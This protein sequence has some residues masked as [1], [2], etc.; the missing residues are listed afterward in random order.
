MNYLWHPQRRAG[1]TSEEFTQRGRTAMFRTMGMMIFVA[2]SLCAT[3]GEAWCA[4]PSDRGGQPGR[5]AAYIEPDAFLLVE[6][7]LERFDKSAVLDFFRSDAAEGQKPDAAHTQTRAALENWIVFDALREAGARRLYLQLTLGGLLSPQRDFTVVVPVE[8]GG[9]HDV[10]ASLMYRGQ[11]DGSTEVPVP[12][13]Q[14]PRYDSWPLNFETC[15]RVGDVVVCGRKATVQRF[16]AGPSSPRPELEAAYQ[17][18]GRVG[19]PAVRVMLLPPVDSARVLTE[20]LQ[21]PAPGG[22]A[23]LGETLARGVRWAALGIELRP[24][25]RAL[26]TVQSADAASARAFRDLWGASSA[27]I[28]DNAN[29]IEALSLIAEFMGAVEP[30][31]QNDSVV[32]KLDKENKSIDKT[33]SIVR[34]TIDRVRQQASFAQCATNLKAMGLALHEFHAAHNHFPAAAIA[35]ESGRPLLSWRVAV[36]PFLGKMELYKQFHLDEPWDSEHNRTLVPL[37]PPVYA[38][39]A[40]KRAAEGMTTY[41]APIGDGTVFPKDRAVEIKEIT[42][43]T[44]QTIMLVEADEDQGVV[45]TQPKD[46]ELDP[47]NPLRGLGHLHAGRVHLLLCDGSFIAIGTQVDPNDLAGLFTR[48]R[49]DVHANTLPILTP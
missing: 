5:I 27:G 3:S 2:A 30:E 46:L 42:D 41:L 20:L 37:M 24:D 12:E 39:T 1:Q 38:C 32:V 45:W 25:A 34:R 17:A 47:A 23:P 29:G 49:G 16:A 48:S 33:V 43:G 9:K 19:E 10:V 15:E 44:S 36:L 35:D 7:N 4:E 6:L 31:V 40:H 18:A 28:A 11:S 22:K 8:K 13:T 26:L 21:M 14:G